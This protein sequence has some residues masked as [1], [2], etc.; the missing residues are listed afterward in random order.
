MFMILFFLIFTDGIVK[1]SAQMPC[2][3]VGKGKLCDEKGQNECQVCCDK[4]YRGTCGN[5]YPTE[6]RCDSCGEF[7]PSKKEKQLA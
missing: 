3:Y 6:C 2:G 1:C 5:C 7:P 4:E